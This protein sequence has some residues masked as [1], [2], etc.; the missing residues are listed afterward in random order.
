MH[1]ALELEG[2]EH[3]TK[4]QMFSPMYQNMGLVVAMLAAAETLMASW[5]IVLVSLWV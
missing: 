5:A 1:Q 2:A 3:K 4:M